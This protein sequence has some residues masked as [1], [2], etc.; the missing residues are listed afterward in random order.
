ME[1]LRHLARWFVIAQE[2][3]LVDADTV[4]HL[5]TIARH[6]M[7]QVVHHFGLRAVS[8]HF[9]VESGVHVHGYRLD[10]LAMLTEPLEEWANRLAAFAV[11]NPQHACSLGIHDHRGV[12]MALVQGELV[13]HQAPEVAGLDGACLR[14][15]AAFV[16]GLEGVPMQAGKLA[17]VA[18]G[19]Y[20]QQALEP[21]LQTSSQAG[22]RLQPIDPFGHPAHTAGSR[23]D[24]RA[25]GAT[26]ADP[27]G[28]GHARGVDA[29]RES[30]DRAADSAHTGALAW[31]GVRARSA[32]YFQLRGERRR[33][34]SLARKRQDQ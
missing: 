28:R 21:G 1:R 29:V 15:Q 27:A 14:F 18:D 6:H 20:P 2:V 11:A 25:I 33:R 8:L 32:G 13:H 19:Q 26:P 3:G 16:E 12:A 23:R 24:A 22:S 10:V 30:T 9:Q 7:E 34:R 31:P 5:T 4:D 17:D